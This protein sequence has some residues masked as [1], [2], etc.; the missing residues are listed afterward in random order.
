MSMCPGPGSL[1]GVPPASSQ[2]LVW[3]WP[4]QNMQTCLH[5]GATTLAVPS[6]HAVPYRSG[7]SP[8]KC[9]LDHPRL[10]DSFLRTTGEGRLYPVCPAWVTFTLIVTHQSTRRSAG[11]HWHV[12]SI[13]HDPSVSF[14]L[15]PQ[16]PKQCLHI[17]A[18]QP[19]ALK[20]MNKAHDNPVRQIPTVCPFHRCRH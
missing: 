9:V 19:T 11:A 4:S 15:Y 17:T 16:G 8:P 3:P 2:V 7:F 20:Q 6:A 13:R 5:L 14:R 18:A 10:G 12:R 1:P